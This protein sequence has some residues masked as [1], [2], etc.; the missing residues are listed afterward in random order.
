MNCTQVDGEDNFVTFHN[1]LVREEKLTRQLDNQYY[2]NLR[3]EVQYWDGEKF[4]KTRAQNKHYKTH[5]IS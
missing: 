5:E 3:K 4:V 1:Q 2:E